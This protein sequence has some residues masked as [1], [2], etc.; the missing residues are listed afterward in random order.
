MNLKE[1]LNK[2]VNLPE[3]VFSDLKEVI[4]PQKLSKKGFFL[5]EDEICS[6]MAFVE[7]G[8]L[9]AFEYDEKGNEKTIYF[10]FLE[11]NPI[12]C[13]F[14]SFIDNTPST[15]SIQALTDCELLVIFKQDLYSLYEKHPSMERLGRIIAEQN[16]L[17]ALNRIRDFQ[18]KSAK[19]RY[20]E[21]IELY[22]Q[23]IQNV[24]SHHI[25]S[26]LGVT[27]HSLSRIKKDCLK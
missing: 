15:I 1:T 17:S 27:K 22:P 13:S 11:K 8:F 14:A 12:I 16:Y 7:K 10:N 19:K 2:Y 18:Y 4:T 21:I 6:K 3:E 5:K 9:R 25:S 24:S 23:L 26:Y 20:Q